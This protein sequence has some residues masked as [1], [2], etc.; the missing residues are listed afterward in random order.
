MGLYVGQEYDRFMF[1]ISK[2]M[3]GGCLPI[4]QE[5]ILFLESS[6]PCVKTLKHPSAPPYLEALPKELRSLTFYHCELNGRQGECKRRPSRFQ[7][8]LSVVGKKAWA[9]EQFKLGARQ[10]ES[11]HFRPPRVS[12]TSQNSTTSLVLSPQHKP[13]VETLHL[14]TIIKR[15]VFH[16]RIYL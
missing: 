2:T 16:F 10:K 9:A 6:L 5:W 4:G 13:F 7:V 1:L 12:R 11:S 8:V 3:T 15:S 14:Q